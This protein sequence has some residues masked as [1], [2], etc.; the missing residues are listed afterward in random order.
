MFTLLLKTSGHGADSLAH[1][2]VRVAL[3]QTAK[4]VGRVG[5]MKGQLGATTL[6][7]DVEICHTAGD[8]KLEGFIEIHGQALVRLVSIDALLDAAKGCEVAVSR[9]ALGNRTVRGQFGVRDARTPS[10]D[11]SEVVE[12]FPNVLYRRIDLKNDREVWQRASF[13]RSNANARCAVR[14]PDN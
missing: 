8:R 13:R 6:W 11:V 4:E 14:I 2:L 9:G 7:G 12:H 1:L 5:V 10:L 3:R